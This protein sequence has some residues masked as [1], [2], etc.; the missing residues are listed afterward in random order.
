MN[1]AALDRAAARLAASRRVLVFSGAGISAESGVPTFRDAGGLWENHSI[2]DVATREGFRRNPVLVGEF[3]E[4]RRRGIAGVE[5][6]PGHLAIA[7]LARFF[8]ELTVVTQNVDGLHQRAGS[9]GVLEIHGSLRRARCAGECGNVVDPFPTPCAEIPPR[10]ACGAWL[11]PDVVWFGEMLPEAPWN[12]A[13]AA[14]A[15]CDVALVVGTSGAV[16][17]AAGIPVAARRGGAFAI[18]V[19]PEASELT[20]SVDLVLRG[21][22]G[23]ILPRLVESLEKAG[24]RPAS[25]G[26]A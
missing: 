9:N 14:A 4:A 7:R 5:P 16:W 15:R 24:V 11:R 19:N 17:P 8:D 23:A 21:P 25:P 13:M 2:E 26:N 1:D 22:S 18:E 6:N 3:Y 20:D 12:A 10:C